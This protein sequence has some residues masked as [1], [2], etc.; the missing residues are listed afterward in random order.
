MILIKV[1]SNGDDLYYIEFSNGF[2]AFVQDKGGMDKIEEEFKRQQEE[3]WEAT[4]GG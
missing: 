2:I 4:L 1:K 3:D